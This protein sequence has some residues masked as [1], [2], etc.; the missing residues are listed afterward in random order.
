MS[1]TEFGELLRTVRLRSLL[2]LEGLAEASGVSVRAISDMERGKS[3]PRQ[4]TL[5]ELMDALGLDPS[6]RAALV[7]ASGRRGTVVPRQLPPDPAAFRAREAAMTSAL[8]LTEQVSA[9]GRHALVAAIS[10]MAGVGKTALAVHWAHEVADRFPDGQLYV[11]LRG[12]EEAGRPVDA[13]DALGGFL[14][15]LG[16]P[17]K[18]IPRGTEERAALFREQAVNRRLVVVLDNA[19][20][21]EHARPLLPASAGCLTIVTS[22]SRLSALSATEG[23]SLIGLDVW[24]REEALAA[25]A[26]RIGGDRCQAEPEAAAEIVGLCG[27]L[28]LAVAVVGA[29]LAA[30]PRTSLRGAVRE[31]TEIRPRL[32]A[33]VSDAH[34]G[35]VRTVFSWSYR[36]LSDAAARF[37]RVL[38]LHPGPA[39]SA[40]AAASLAG[41]G[42]AQAW[43]HLRELVAGSL[44]SRDGEGLY[45]LHD[46]VRAYASELAE[47]EG[48]DRLGAE[49]RLLDY[50]RHNAHT[51][52]RYVSRL[53]SDE[54]STSAPGVVQLEFD[55][56][57]EALDWFRQ[58]EATESAVLR[59]TTD[60][61]LLRH[62][63][64]L[65]QEWVS[66]NSVM[67]HW[68]EEIAVTR[69]ALDAALALDD[70]SAVVRSCLNRARALIEA[71]YPDQVD[72]PVDLVLG[73]LGRV[74]T[75]ARARAERNL[76]W[77]RHQQGRFAESLRHARR[78]LE[79]YRTLG[80]PKEIARAQ[81]EV[82]YSLTLVDEHREAIAV[83]ERAIVTLREFG[84]DRLEAGAWEAI[85][86]ARHRL[87]EPRTAIDAYETAAAL[88][89]AVHDDYGHALVLDH[90]AD[91]RADLGDVEG[92]RAD[93]T[94]AADLLEALRVVR[95]AEI[96]AKAHALPG[97]GTRNS[98]PRR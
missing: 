25:L 35:D 68:T 41:V 67:G 98:T 11:N 32:D 17:M 90:L 76:G 37:F 40:E 53:P 28:P 60:R 56:R 94:R 63:V 52:N 29:Q 34:R 47:S 71:G 43:R 69:I 20:D 79:L 57:D 46:L 21:S 65:T 77:L 58:E 86:F 4:G 33:L 74:P 14:R 10:G 26:A 96:R 27:Y 2:T 15:A 31:L 36:T 72:E 8:A 55:D 22:R 9:A 62:L 87:G 1:E 95:S 78:S 12:F 66:Y 73:Q 51:A 16:V 85:G 45:V 3:L 70:P 48:D 88:Y 19:L 39:M 92:A 61:R 54:P 18:E 24:S 49:I 89:S 7:R 83:S 93:W 13:G 30:E 59:R 84:D 75:A 38:A 91:A 5:A 80:L 64:D 6:E 81:M 44:L 42:P 50:L 23:A 82:G 97:P